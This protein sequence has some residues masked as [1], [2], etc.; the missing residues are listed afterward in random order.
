MDMDW[1]AAMSSEIFREYCKIELQ[2]E[3]QAPQVAQVK[4]EEVLE[5]FD[6]FQNMV[7]SNPQ[8]KLAFKELKE[9]FSS[10]LEYRDGVD[11]NFVNGVML[12]DLGDE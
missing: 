12:L 10:D 9:K 11:P 7:N 3:A 8:M 6:K 5:D 4:E 2:K 1:K